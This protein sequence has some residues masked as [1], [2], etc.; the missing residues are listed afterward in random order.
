[1]TCNTAYSRYVWAYNANGNSTPTI[2]TQSTSV[3]P[4]NFP[5]VIT[6]A[7]SSITETSASSGGNVTSDGG[8]SVT[9]RGVC[10]SISPNPTTADSKTTDGSGTG[11]FTSS[12]TGLTPN[13]LYY[14]RA[15]ATNSVGTSYGN[16]LS[17][18][19]LANLPTLTTSPVISITQTTAT[20]GGNISSDGGAAITARGVCWSTTANPVVTGS[21]TTDGT[22]T[23]PF[24][25]N[26]NGLT[27]G[28]LYYVRA[29]ATNIVGTSYGNQLTFTTLTLPTVTTT[30]VTDITQTSATS[31]GNVT[32]DGGSTVTARGVCWSSTNPQPTLANSHTIDGSGTGVFISNMS[33]LTTGSN[34]FVRAYATNSTGT[35]YGI[36]KSFLAAILPIVTTT[37]VSNITYNSATTGGNVTSDGGSPVTQRGV[38]ISISPNPTYANSHTI[39][40]SGT[41][42]F[43]SNLTGLYANTIYYIKAYAFNGVGVVYGDQVSFTTTDSLYIGNLYGGGV[44]FYLDGTGY[45]GLIAATSDQTQN[46]WGCSGF[47]CGCTWDGMGTGQQNTAEIVTFCGSGTAAGTCSNLV[48]N[49]YSDWFLPSKDEIS[50]LYWAKSLVGGFGNYNYWSSSE[51]TPLKSWSQNFTDGSQDNTDKTT[52]LHVR[53]IRAF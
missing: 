47:T 49:G 46:D 31:G 44:I 53:A 36:A 25:S 14:V 33:G 15:Y 30:D 35:S 17:F 24:V 26:I 38:C 48:L 8:L 39:N 23:G 3:C 51:W 22:G 40:G 5:T 18:T 1:M 12:L 6:T 42:V 52:I 28:T 45:H 34:Y 10:W 20:S 27:G 21:H 9:V 29:Y 43:V 41:G 4:S 7:I 32:S 37:N 16:Q 2:L 11:S 50:V 13:T 19:T